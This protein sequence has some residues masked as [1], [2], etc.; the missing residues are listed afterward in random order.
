MEDTYRVVKSM[1]FEDRNLRPLELCGHGLEDLGGIGEE[2]RGASCKCP[3]PSLG[4]C[5]PQPPPRYSNASSS[6]APSQWQCTAGLGVREVVMGPAAK[7]TPLP[8]P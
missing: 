7:E 3:P 1:D 4:P 2:L 8:P 5:L 6:L